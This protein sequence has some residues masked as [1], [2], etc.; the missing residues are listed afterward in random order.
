MF[1]EIEKLEARGVNAEYVCLIFATA[2]TISYEELIQG[3]KIIK[4]NKY[5]SIAA[6]CEFSE[7]IERALKIKE[8]LVWWEKPKNQFT[9]TQDLEKS[10]FD[11]GRF[12]WVRVESFKKNKA[13]FSR[14]TYPMVIPSLLVQDIDT[15]EDWE[16]MELK[17][18]KLKKLLSKSSFFIN[19]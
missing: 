2:P 1:E 8:G 14:N 5:D 12:Y 15:P 4:S 13:F 19:K 7:P 6:V 16:M 17:F 11:A 18:K 9:R 3:Y 10:Y